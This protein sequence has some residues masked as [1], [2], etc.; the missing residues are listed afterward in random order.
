MTNSKV[1]TR[2]AALEK[3][4]KMGE[5]IYLVTLADGTQR[6]M[7]FVELALYCA[8]R[9]AVI[10]SDKKITP[11]RRMDRVTS[12]TLIQGK[13]S[14]CTMIDILEAYVKEQTE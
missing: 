11:Y 9:V 12:F 10:N 1:I 2:L 3:T 13:Q 8:D 6:R 7:D 4:L 14:Q 5:P